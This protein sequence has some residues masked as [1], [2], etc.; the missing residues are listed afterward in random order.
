MV[1]GAVLLVLHGLSLLLRWLIE[2]LILFQE[3][4]HDPGVVLGGLP[5]LLGILVAGIVGLLLVILAVQ[6]W[7]AF[8][9]V[10]D[11][12]AIVHVLLVHECLVKLP[13]ERHLG[14]HWRR[15][16][17]FEAGALHAEVLGLHVEFSTARCTLR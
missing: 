1:L 7:C 15:F 5:D 10:H 3:E 14:V 6:L 13:R 8:G 4:L 2:F 17:L 9:G 12:L 11:W 16:R